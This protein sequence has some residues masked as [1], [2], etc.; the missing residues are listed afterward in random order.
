MFKKCTLR[1]VGYFA[2][3]RL[4]GLTKEYYLVITVRASAKSRL[5]DKSRIYNNTRLL[6]CRHCRGRS[7]CWRISW[8][9]GN[10]W[11]LRDNGR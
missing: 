2:R 10:N 1:L 3:V 8:L 9:L 11:L 5:I 4:V 7:S 6:D